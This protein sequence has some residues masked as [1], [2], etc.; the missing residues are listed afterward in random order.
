MAHRSQNLEWVQNGK[1]NKK[2]R[3]IR[4]IVAIEGTPPPKVLDT[5]ATL[6]NKNKNMVITS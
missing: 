6:K 5:V 4:N 1:E 3:M 2:I